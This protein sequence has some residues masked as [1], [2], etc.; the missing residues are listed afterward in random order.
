M[1]KIFS[2]NCLALLT[3]HVAINSFSHFSTNISLQ[4][5]ALISGPPLLVA[6]FYNHIPGAQP[7]DG[8][9]DGYYIF[10]CN[11]DLPEIVFEFD[12]FAFPITHHFNLGP[13]QMGSSY[14][15]GSILGTEAANVWT[16]GTIFM[17]DDYTIFDV[18]NRR[19]GFATLADL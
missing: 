12:G 3:L 1:G 18:G 14:C 5:A 7:A 2:R 10:P 17:I 9:H 13:W 6:Q 4:S 8:A 15:L 11:T 16:M 19:V